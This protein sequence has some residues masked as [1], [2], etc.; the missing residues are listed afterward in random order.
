MIAVQLYTLRSRLQDPAELG[1]V[2]GRLREIGYRAV[3]VAGLGPNT[4]DRFGEELRRAD[5]IACAAH[6]GL[7]RLM[8]EPD[9]VVAECR[10]WGC[11]YV[12]IPS[13]PEE[14]RSMDGYRRFG[15]LTGLL[16]DKLQTQDL[17]LAYH[18][19]AFELERFDRKTALELLHL[20]NWNVAAEPDTY[21]LQ[22]GG[23][24]AAT[25]IRRLSGK[26]PLVHLKDLAIERGDPVDAEI[27]EGNL[28]WPDILAACREANTKWLIV[29]QDAPRRD[30]LESVAISY[31]NLTKVLSAI[32]W[33]G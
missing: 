29:E 17:A 3:E 2:L 4:V 22:Y 20:G 18:N 12:V 5:L 21:W 16:A 33:E 9:S 24:N 19:H 31:A 11:E 10:E 26:A 14:Y 13:V 27:G 6:V 8:R 32:G 15:A 7:E 23:V 28:D 25:W 1:G 30:P